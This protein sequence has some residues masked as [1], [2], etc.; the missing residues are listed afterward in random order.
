MLLTREEMSFDFGGAQLTTKRDGELLAWMFNQFLYGEMTGIQVGHWLYNA[1]TY[2]AARFLAQ[3]AIEELQHVDNFLR[4]LAIIGEEPSSPHRLVRFLSTGM[5]PDTWSEHVSQE[6][7]IG[8]GL[9][10]MCFYAIIDT[11]DDEEIAR[12]LRRA[13][14]QEERH[15]EFGEKET[16]RL[17]AGNEPLRRQLLGLSLLSLWATRR[18]AGWMERSWERDHPVLRQLSRFLDR[19]NE[20]TELRLLRMGL[21]DRP[22]EALGRVEALRCVAEAQGAKAVRAAVSIPKRLLPFTGNPK[23]LTDTYLNDPTLRQAMIKA[24]TKARTSAA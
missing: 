13:V 10:L 18:L 6:M 15:V 19:V 23:R 21:V 8:E 1:P 22:L 2:E 11:I 14:K 4:C 9:V 24:R 5:M 17:I 12:I 20:A 16:M 3:Q 7:A